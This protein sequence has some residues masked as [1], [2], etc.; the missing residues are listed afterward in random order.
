VNAICPG[1][2]ETEMAQERIQSIA[3]EEGI[4][5]EASKKRQT[6]LVPM[7]RM[8]QPEEIGNLVKFLILNG[9]TSI[10]GQAI[11]INNGSFMI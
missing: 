10:T 4:S 2:V 9:E 11:D 8:S 3:D 6:D 1:W 7:K 5:Y